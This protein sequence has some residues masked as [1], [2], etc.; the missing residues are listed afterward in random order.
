M[1]HISLP[2]C[3]KYESFFW[4]PIADL[5]VYE[6]IIGNTFDVAWPLVSLL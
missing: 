3:D 6:L 2:L 5:Q 4:Q 1:A